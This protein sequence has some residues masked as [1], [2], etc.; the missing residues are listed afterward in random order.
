MLEIDDPHSAMY[1]LL[2]S[3]SRQAV[4]L[5]IPLEVQT[6]VAEIA[7]EIRRIRYMWR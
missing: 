7:C 5:P 4:Y 2:D 6:Q 3:I 1:R